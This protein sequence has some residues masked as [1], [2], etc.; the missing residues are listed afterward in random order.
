LLIT[1]LLIDIIYWNFYYKYI[2]IYYI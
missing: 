1:F 2:L